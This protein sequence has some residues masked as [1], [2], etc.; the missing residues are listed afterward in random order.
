MKKPDVDGRAFREKEKKDCGVFVRLH[1]TS[2]LLVTEKLT[3]SKQAIA[4]RATRHQSVHAEVIFDYL[5]LKD[6]CV[7]EKVS[8]PEADLFYF[9][10]GGSPGRSGRGLSLR[11]LDQHTQPHRKLVKAST[12]RAGLFGCQL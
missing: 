3:S 5:A 4:T 6:C 12:F 7:F 1:E 8:L 10:Q 11:W 9:L 2:H